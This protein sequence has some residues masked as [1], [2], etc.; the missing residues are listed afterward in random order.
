M[1]SARKRKEPAEIE[2]I[3][4]H[5]EPGET[6]LQGQYTIERFLNSGG[7]GITY[8]A[9]DSLD[10]RVVIKECFAAAFCHRTRSIV[11]VRTREQQDDFR[12][13]VKLFVQEAKSLSKLKHP[14]IVGVHQVF[15]DNQT[16]YMALDF[17]DGRDL[18]D[19]LSD[20]N[21]GLSP[22]AVRSILMQLLDAV[23][24]M[25]KE[26]L[27]HRDISPDNILL[28]A[29]RKPVLIDFGASRQQMPKSERAMSAFRVVKDGYSP[30]EFYLA[31]SPQYPSSDIYAL[32]ATFYHL[33][34]GEAPPNSQARLA[35]IA[36]GDPDP[37]LPLF[38]KAVGYDQVFC[39]AIDKAMRVL[40]KDRLQDAG[41]WIEMITAARPKP[42]AVVP[43]KPVQ[44]ADDPVDEKISALVN[45]INQDVMAAS[46][47][48]EPVKEEVAAATPPKPK[49]YE[50]LAAMFQEDDTEEP[51]V[52][53]EE[54]AEDAT[55][56]TSDIAAE[57]DLEDEV[58]RYVPP[59][60][61][62]EEF[63]PAEAA[64]PSVEIPK[65]ARM[66]LL[67]ASAA[68]IAAFGVA[69][70]TFYST[71]GQNGKPALNNL[72]TS[73][74][75][76]HAGFAD[77]L[78]SA[79]PDVT[80]A[81]FNL[82]EPLVQPAVFTEPALAKDVETRMPFVQ[83]PA[84]AAPIVSAQI[85]ALPTPITAIVDVKAT[86]SLPDL[87]YVP[88]EL[89]PHLAPPVATLEVFFQADTP[90]SPIAEE[91]DLAT[92]VE[93]APVDVPEQAPA[94]PLVLD[95]ASVMSGWSVRLPFTTA[96]GQP[97]TI[98]TVTADGAAWVQEGL[99]VVSVNG[100][101]VGSADEIAAQLRATVQPGDAGTIPVT[102]GLRSTKDGSE[103]TRTVD[104]PVVHEIVFL[105]GTRFEVQSVDGN[106]RTVV[107]FV[108]PHVDTDLEA[109][110]V[111]LAFVPTGQEISGHDTFAKI[112]EQS[113]T[114][115]DV[116]LNFTV[117]R[118]GGIW[119]A[120]YAYRTAS[121]N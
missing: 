67:L 52:V 92:L 68:T 30:Q 61:V 105:N 34:A 41:E 51:E 70:A 28:D 44:V 38:E 40:P 55:E 20:P 82:V 96:P 111:L 83:A 33:I 87:A 91:P 90:A 12:S 27:L 108:P 26:K 94:G 113:A 48:P 29:S 75:V 65:P 78:S 25:H 104:L 80:P 88:V 5:L 47:E 89:T 109:G 54:L 60:Q 74:F 32:G 103:T 49:R 116:V 37:C 2:P 57:D 85:E 77:I 19:T 42:A 56:T 115:N 1:A 86:V 7:F 62:V 119:L 73:A 79:E 63:A 10:R 16:A 117:L 9:R 98:D 11:R 53:A 112:V 102:F 81:P 36:G 46:V 15:E 76:G 69:A 84:A 39:D 120:S 99:E 45:S 21:H 24:Y 66:R 14:N 18:H 64:T 50:A 23:G 71:M 106:W 58:E 3:S 114:P 93:A 72:D 17:I 4:D 13:I 43:L 121:L 59:V 97:V 118:D 8:T 31:G 110:D 95:A 6:L 35:A 107:A 100:Q 101:P 22:A